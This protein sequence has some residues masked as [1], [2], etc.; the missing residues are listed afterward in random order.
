MSFSNH[1]FGNWT[2]SG[3]DEIGIDGIVIFVHNI[4]VVCF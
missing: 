2:V 1:C 3:I 4:M